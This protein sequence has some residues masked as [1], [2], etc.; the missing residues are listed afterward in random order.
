MWI[1]LTPGVPGVASSKVFSPAAERRNRRSFAEWSSTVPDTPGSPNPSRPGTNVIKLFTNVISNVYSKLLC[2]LGKHFKRRHDTQHNDTQHNNIQHSDMQHNDIHHN[3]T[4]A[5]M[6]SVVML[7]GIYAVSLR[8]KSLRWVSWRLSNLV[9]S[10]WLRP[11]AF[12][13]VEHLK[14]ALFG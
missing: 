14:G 4:F 2:F 13:R 1:T 5:K 8:W 6:L 7:N 9:Y 12:H 3:G 10:L 11:V